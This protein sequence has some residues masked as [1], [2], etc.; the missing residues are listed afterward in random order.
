MDV[1]IPAVLR[2]GP[3]ENT[4]DL[5]RVADNAVSAHIG[6]FLCLVGRKIDADG[7]CPVADANPGIVATIKDIADDL[8]AV[9][10][11]LPVIL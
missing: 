11:G 5:N 3:M 4:V 8:T 10:N 7:V 9:G 2:A 1:E 6:Y